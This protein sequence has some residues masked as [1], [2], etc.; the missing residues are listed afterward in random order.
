MRSIL[1]TGFGVE[2][3]EVGYEDTSVTRLT[4]KAL[5]SKGFHRKSG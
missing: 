1:V 3:S 4:M 2:A 5:P